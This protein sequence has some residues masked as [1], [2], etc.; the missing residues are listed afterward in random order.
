MNGAINCYNSCNYYFYYNSTEDKYY[1]TYNDSCP[2]D[3]NKLIFEKKQCI[4]NCTKDS[5]YSYEF[6]NTCYEHCPSNISVRSDTKGFYCEVK[7][8]FN[9]PFENI[10][11]QICVDECTI[12]QRAK[13]ICKINYISDDENNKEIEEKVI[14]E[15]KEELMNDF[16]TTDVDKGKDI[17]I[18][19]K[20]STITITTTENQKNKI[21]SNTTIIDLGECETKLK[22]EY[23]ISENQ[24]LYIFKID[25]KQIR[26]KIPKIVY[27]VYYPLFGKNLIRLNLTVCKD[28]EIKLYIRYNL[29]DNIDIINPSSDYYNDICYTHTSEDGTD[30][31]LSD[32]RKNFVDN[33]LTVCEEDCD[34]KDYNYT[35]ERVVCFCKVKTNPIMKIKDIVIDKNKL[36]NSFTDFKNI[37]NIKVLNCYKLIFNLDL[38]KNN[39]ANFIMIII[40]ILFLI[41][42]FIFYCKDYYYLKKIL[43]MIV[44]FQFNSSLVKKFQERK[45]KEEQISFKNMKKMVFVNNPKTIKIRKETVKFKRENISEFN[46]SK[47]IFLKFLKILKKGYHLSN[48]IKRNN[49]NRNIFNNIAIFNNNKSSLKDIFNKNNIQKNG[50]NNIDE[51]QIYKM[52]LNIN[53]NSDA[54]LNDL[55][56][57]LAIQID[58]RTYFQYYLSLIRTKHPLFFSFYPS[59]DYN[60]QIIK[61]FLLFFNFIFSFF[62]NALFFDDETMHKIY[63]E[64]GTFDFIYNIPQTLC[65]SLI[66]GFIGAIIETLA[67]T[68]SNLISLKQNKDNKNI[69]IIKNEI[70]KKIKTKISK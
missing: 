3:F 7:C 27:D 11:T 21:S 69:R 29:T 68:D 58:K 43:N 67:L 39:Y 59:F 2:N 28:S 55:D 6:R 25:V 65:S 44:Y 31:S 70:L 51:K 10:Y 35:I 54:E 15:T 34:F 33:N 63:E 61:I 45:K 64:K 53:K 4:D 19:Q 26:F 37:A 30:I 13:G 52:F 8:P 32:R 23:N 42:I 18:E 47:P 57:K 24:S 66:S 20:D 60:S 40:I 50:L 49:R 17:V 48:P 41:T 9:S 22:G 62:I 46:I 38:F 36:F 16:D 14:N 5:N 1:C 56:Y 12:T